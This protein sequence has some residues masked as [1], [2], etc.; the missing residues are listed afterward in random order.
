MNCIVSALELKLFSLGRRSLRGD[1]IALFQYLKGA[2]NE[3]SIGLFPLVTG[4]G[5]MALS[6]ARVSLGWISGNAS[7]QRGLLSTEMGSSGRWLSNHPWMCSKTVWMWCSGT[8]CSGGLLVR[9]VWLW[10]DS[11]IFKVFSNLNNSVIL[12]LCSD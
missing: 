1:L 5:E 7:L 2:Y 9:V 8:R 4:Q 6:C 12:Y 3:S 10:L 11:L